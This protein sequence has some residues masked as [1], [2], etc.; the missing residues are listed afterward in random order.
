MF[1]IGSFAIIFNEDGN[2]LL[3]HRQDIDVWN[4]PGGRVETRELPDE[5]VVREVK[6]ETGLEVVIERLVGV[7][8]KVDKDE[9]VFAF[10]CRVVGGKLVL[11]DEA[12]QHCYFPIE[13]IPANTPPKQTERIQ[14]AL[15]FTSQPIFRRQTAPSTQSIIGKG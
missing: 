6:E 13:K 7:Y 8:G 4:L 10:V 11:S 14:D 5:A 9:I 12:D 1:S 2:V 15:S 3:S